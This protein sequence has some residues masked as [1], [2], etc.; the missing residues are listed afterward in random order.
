M[1]RR[2]GLGRGLDSLIPN[3]GG[4]EKKDSSENTEKA[5]AKKRKTSGTRSHKKTAPVIEKTKDKDEPVVTEIET[6]INADEG[7]DEPEEV[8]Y[9]YVDE[10]G[11]PVDINE[12][13]D[14]YVFVDE[15]GNPI[16]EDSAKNG[17]E[18]VEYIE[19]EE[20]SSEDVSD[21][22]SS[23]EAEESDESES[24]EAA[25][26]K[27][28][29][30]NAVEKTENPSNAENVE[31]S[32][33]TSDVDESDDQTPAEKTEQSADHAVDTPDITVTVD[34]VI[35]S[36]SESA[37]GEDISTNKT[38]VL[39][40]NNETSA[41]EDSFSEMPMNDFPSE[42]TED[43]KDGEVISMRISL[44]EPNRD[45]P[46]KYFDD[47]AISELADSVR[48][49]GVIQPLLVQKKDGYYEIIAG[50][51][52][53]RAAKK[54]GLKEVPVIVKNFS[55]QEAVEVALIENIQREDLNC[56]EE[57]AALE[58]LITCYGMTQE[59]AALQLGKAQSTIA[60]KLRLLRLTESERTCILENHLTERHARALL[61]LGSGEERC[62]AIDKIVRLGLNVE[63]TELMIDDMIGK[64]RER[65]S[66]RRRAVLFK[67]VRLFTN[68][69]A[70]AVETMQTAGI[71]AASQK[72]QFDDYIEYRIRIPLLKHE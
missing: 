7:V 3:R 56:F 9:V 12:N 5:P 21:V 47:A 13:P 17:E 40:G 66:I 2:G 4:S 25:A 19:V 38:Y 31:V 18:P 43:K 68:T 57:A 51:R 52:R 48:Q 29:A 58:K 27:T 8:E 45:Q 53:W 72:I 16:L 11:N 30:V 65:D 59:D 14:D 62:K 35:S 49:F 42:E 63:K 33:S 32:T 1:A 60:N 22:E 28:P 71:P 34:N 41:A 64:A 70:K 15:N 20:N 6:V 67:D 37:K 24:F 10:D 50:E 36:D 44:V 23:D 54:A 69:I 61:R 46:R 26:D 39:D 55:G